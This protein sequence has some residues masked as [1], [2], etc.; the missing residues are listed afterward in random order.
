MREE[1]FQRIQ[2]SM[3][4]QKGEEPV[5][6]SKFVKPRV[7]PSPVAGPDPLPEAATEPG[8]SESPTDEPPPPIT[9]TGESDPGPLP[10]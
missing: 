4:R 6:A 1:E 7:K 2:E 10:G 9:Q 8:P 5:A 3:A